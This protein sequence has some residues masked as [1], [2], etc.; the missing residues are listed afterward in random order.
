MVN[1]RSQRFCCEGSSHDLLDRAFDA[2]DNSTRDWLNIP[3]RLVL[4]DTYAGAFDFGAP[5]L[6]QPLKGDELPEWIHAFDTM[7]ELA[8][9]MSIDKK[10]S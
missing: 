7:E 4:D 2:Y 1:R 3:S 6:A 10:A 5:N 8:D 9:G